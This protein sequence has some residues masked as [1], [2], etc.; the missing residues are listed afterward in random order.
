[1]N[2][3]SS[4]FCSSLSLLV[5]GRS[6][7]S[8]GCF[9]LHSCETAQHAPQGMVRCTDGVGADC[10]YFEWRGEEGVNAT[11]EE[12]ARAGP[13]RCIHQSVAFAGRVKFSRGRGRGR[14]T[15]IGVGLGQGTETVRRIASGT[16]DR[17]H[18]RIHRESQETDSCC[19]R[20][21]SFGSLQGARDEKEYDV[22]EV[23]LAE[24]VSNAS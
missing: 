19:R 4:H 3:G 17:D 14:E 18:E 9:D 23:P 20:E 7:L 21:N 6:S 5:R 22:R 11:Q 1:M 13:F 15:C 24:H 10:A 2:F 8:S 16:S 12:D